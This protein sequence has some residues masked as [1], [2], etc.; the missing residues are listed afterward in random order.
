MFIGTHCAYNNIFFFLLFRHKAD[1][2][3]CRWKNGNPI[4]C[5]GS[6]FWYSVI[7]RSFA[8][9]SGWLL[10]CFYGSI[11]VS[12]N[13]YVRLVNGVYDA[14]MYANAIKPSNGVFCFLSH[15]FIRIRIPFVA[16]FIWCT[17]EFIAQNMNKYIISRRKYKHKTQ[18]ASSRQ[19]HT[20]TQCTASA[21]S[22]RSTMPMP[23]G[24]EGN[25][26]GSL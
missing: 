3:H 23:K 17:L 13:F 25:D 6:R 10:F 12:F 19:F 26:D 2:G 22:N 1:V 18:G 9:G 20:V 11:V 24:G 16:A 7:F 15:S 5:Y 8:A 4:E 14:M 21:K